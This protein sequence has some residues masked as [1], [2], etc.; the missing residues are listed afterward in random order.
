MFGAA[1]ALHA[2]LLKLNRRIATS[3]Q[4]GT[5]AR[6]DFVRVARETSLSKQFA[7]T[8]KQCKKLM[9]FKRSLRTEPHI[10]TVNLN[11]IITSILINYTF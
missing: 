2:A 1:V 4:R 7:R 6:F 5:V 9:D 3:A 10:V 11:A 8:Y